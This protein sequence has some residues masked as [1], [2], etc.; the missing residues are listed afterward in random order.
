MKIKLSNIGLKKYLAYQKN[1]IP[2]DNDEYEVLK[3]VYANIYIESK[4]YLTSYINDGLLEYEKDDEKTTKT[5]YKYPFLENVERIHFE[6]TTNCNFRCDHCRSGDVVRID[7]VNINKLFEAAK[8]FTSLGI[9]RFDFIGGE[10]TLYG[11]KWLELVQYIKQINK[12]AIITVYT[13]G[14]FLEQTNFMIDNKTYKDDLEYLNH[15]YVNG[16]TH[17]LFSIDGEEKLHDKQRHHKGLFKKI[18]R[19]IQ[20]V[21]DIGLKPRLSSIVKDGESQKHLL[22]FANEIYGTNFINLSDAV[23]TLHMDSTNHFSNFI[24]IN[25]G[26]SLRK[27][28]FSIENIPAGMIKCKAFYRPSPT[29]RIKADGSMGICPLMNQ[30]E[31]YGNVHEQSVIEVINNAH[32]SLSYLL[33]SQNDISEYI[34]YLEPETLDRF[35]HICTLRI[36]LHKLA[37]AF[38]DN[39]IKNPNSIQIKKMNEIVRDAF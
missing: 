3:N 21:K 34:K 26:A 19:S 17:I 1:D 23:T 31:L 35:D 10:V 8:L 2:D 11:G 9:K 36:A 32:R 27:G 13:N 6:I 29:L 15:L 7:E 5:L 24:D 18:K 39:E 16:L 30:N 28:N 25:N 33:H 38:Y 12:D 37:I 22:D 14:W 4:D 20:K